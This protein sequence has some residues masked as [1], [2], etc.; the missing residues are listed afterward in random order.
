VLEGPYDMSLSDGNQALG[1]F[2]STNH[3]ETPEYYNT[4]LLCFGVDVG[5]CVYPIDGQRAT[6]PL[7]CG[8]DTQY[9][10]VLVKLET[11]TKVVKPDRKTSITG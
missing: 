4:P 3:V 9:W 1:D 6:L 11:F 10:I 7:C 5:P 8:T 2:K